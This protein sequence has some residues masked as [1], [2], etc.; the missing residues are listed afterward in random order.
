MPLNLAIFGIDR[1]E[2]VIQTFSEIDIW[3]IGGHSL[4]GAMAAE[5]AGQN[6]NEISGLA[7]W[8][9]YPAES[10]DLSQFGLSVLSISASLD[11]LTTPEKIDSSRALL[12]PSTHLSKF[13]AA[14][15][16]DLEPMDRSQA[17]AGHNQSG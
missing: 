16:L 17:M 11:G 8:A 13:W 2:E 3:A 6:A 10:N 1:A 7:L 5:F 12:P 9:A 4:G 15:M 14:T